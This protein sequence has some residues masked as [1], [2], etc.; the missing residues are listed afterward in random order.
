MEGI[1]AMTEVTV[2]IPET[3][4]YYDRETGVGYKLPV[5]KVVSLEQAY[6]LQVPGVSDPSDRRGGLYRKANADG[7]GSAVVPS[8]ASFVIVDSD[9]AN[10]IITLSDF[11]TGAVITLRNGATGY[12]LRSSDPATIAINGGGGE[13]AESAIPANTRTVCQLDTATT[14]LCHD[15]ATDGT[16]TKTEAAAS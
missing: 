8:Y 4:T 10:H 15:T 12:E 11:T 3:G 16:V 13:N 2:T 5:G 7:N 14:W 6:L 9:D 1:E